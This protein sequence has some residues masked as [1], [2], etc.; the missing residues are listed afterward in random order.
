MSASAVSAHSGDGDGTSMPSSL[1]A[2]AR[3]VARV[4]AAFG[5]ADLAPMMRPR[6]E[7][8]EIW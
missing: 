5:L 7:R 8:I 4:Q 6:E 1:G 3:S 2:D